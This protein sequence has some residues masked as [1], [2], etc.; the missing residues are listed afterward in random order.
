MIQLDATDYA[1]LEILKEDG[2]C[3]YSDIAEQVHL[4]RVA[5]R[6][7]INTMKETESFSVLPLL[8]TQRPIRKKPVFLWTSRWSPASWTRWPSS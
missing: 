4:S 8:L 6:E 1:I 7:R 3:S 5:V 2:R